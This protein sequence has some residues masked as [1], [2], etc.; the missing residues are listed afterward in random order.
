[1]DEFKLKNIQLLVFI[2][3]GYLTESQID[4]LQ[5][6]LMAL[7]VDHCTGTQRSW[8]RV[9]DFSGNCLSCIYIALSLAVKLIEK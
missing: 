2:I 5:V 6:V 4:Q 8:V 1:M 7:S 9:L 3:S